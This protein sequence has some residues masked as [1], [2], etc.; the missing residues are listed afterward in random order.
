MSDATEPNP[1]TPKRT[2]F[3]ASETTPVPLMASPLVSAKAALRSGLQSLTTSIHSIVEHFSNQLI[4]LHT[5]LIQKKKTLKTFDDESFIPRS[6]RVSIELTASVAVRETPEFG[7]LSARVREH[8]L[9]YQADVK[10]CMKE[11]LELEVMQL[12][13]EGTSVIVRAVV[14]HIRLSSLADSGTPKTAE[15]IHMIASSVLGHPSFKHDFTVSKEL[16]ITELEKYTGVTTN[17]LNPVPTID[18]TFRTQLRNVYIAPLEQFDKAEK[19]NKLAVALKTATE[20]ELGEEITGATAMV[21]DKEPSVDPVLLEELIESVMNRK[22]AGHQNKSPPA[23]NSSR[24]ADQKLRAPST[25]KSKVKAPATPPG[26]NQNRGGVRNKSPAPASANR[27]ARAAG[28][29]GNGSRNGTN[30]RANRSSSGN[31]KSKQNNSTGKNNS[32]GRQR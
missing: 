5:K 24:G 4:V 14:K 27:D 22:L 1:P 25:K 28:D 32:R 3:S 19:L 29:P 2:R 10:Q 30:S 12:I 13:N 17:R 7:Q 8:T 15:E 16:V 9:Q 23:K 20:L 11:S 26:K 6:A 21:L 18:N 31:K